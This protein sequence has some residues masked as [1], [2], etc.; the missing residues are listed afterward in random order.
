MITTKY[1][2]EAQR[3]V[4]QEPNSIGDVIDSVFYTIA[5]S[6]ICVT[7]F[8]VVGNGVADWIVGM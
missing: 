1:D 8:L 4:N 7:V 2:K 6:L 5:G 3:W